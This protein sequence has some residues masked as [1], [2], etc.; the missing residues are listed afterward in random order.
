M[1]IPVPILD[2]IVKVENG[3]E[4]HEIFNFI[5]RFASS[6]LWNTSLELDHEK[7][8]L[9]RF[10]VAFDQEL[11]INTFQNGDIDLRK[12]RFVLYSEKAIF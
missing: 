1:F 4:L 9:A 12:Q 2:F 8:C 10:I 11:L 7:G 6:L 5:I 3:L